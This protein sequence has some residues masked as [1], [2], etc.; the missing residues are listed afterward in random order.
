MVVSSRSE[1]PITELLGLP[2][3]GKTR[4]L[5][6]ITPHSTTNTD[7]QVIE[8][9]WG[10]NKCVNLF[11]GLFALGIA[12]SIQ[13]LFLLIGN[14]K[15]VR[16]ILMLLERIGGIKRFCRVQS[17]EGPMQAIWGIAW[18]SPPEKQERIIAK[19]LAIRFDATGYIG[20]VSCP[21]RIHLGRL[22]QR[23]AS[24]GDQ[25]SFEFS[26]PESY[27]RGR[28]A[29]AVLLRS[30]RAEKMNIVFVK[31]FDSRLVH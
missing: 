15:L 5:E 10:I 27:Q 9:G 7:R 11:F 30:I 24:S 28:D 29:M 1:R 31:S 12:P 26:S 20:Y 25:R 8:K 18:R 17:D 2:G 6:E 13:I 14:V 22:S 4:A 16:P 23:A 3:A 21:R 19:L